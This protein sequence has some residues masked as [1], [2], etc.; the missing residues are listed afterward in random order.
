MLSTEV[1]IDIDTPHELKCVTDTCKWTELSV[2]VKHV[3]KGVV[4]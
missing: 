1:W 3:G 2:I 4:N